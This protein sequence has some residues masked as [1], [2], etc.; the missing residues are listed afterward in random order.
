MKLSRPQTN[1]L[2]V[3]SFKNTIYTPL[4][5]RGIKDPIWRFLLIA[6]VVMSISFTFVIDFHRDDFYRLLLY[7]CLFALVNS[8]LEELLW[9]GLILPRFVDHAGEQ[10]G[11]IVTSLGF[12]FYHYSL[13]FPW[14]IC[15][16]FSLCGLLMGGV[17]IRS[18]G[19]VP[20]MILHFF[21][22][23]LFALSGIIF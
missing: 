5:W 21:M 1:Y 16:V 18:K 8:I 9:R 3:G 19:L 7:G 13:G 14:A 11:L 17:A 12:G 6:I 22:N 15:A 23:V 4:I 2:S 10:M 20:V